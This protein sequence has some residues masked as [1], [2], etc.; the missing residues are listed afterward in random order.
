M[1]PFHAVQP[2]G[3][4]CLSECPPQGHKSCQ[5]TLWAPL[6]MGLQI[7]SGVCSSAGFPQGHS[8][9]QAVSPAFSPPW[10][11]NGS[12]LHYGPPWVA[13]GQPLSPWSSPWAA[14]ASLLLYWSNS[15]PSF[16]DLGADKVVSLIY[17]H[18]SLCCNCIVFSMPLNT[19]STNADGLLLAQWQVHL[20]A[21]SVG[22]LTEATSLVP[23]CLSHRKSIQ[24]YSITP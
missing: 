13:G 8:L 17:F 1:G 21:R 2:Y 4:E 24:P 23:F 15:S 16:T 20:R 3:T 12:L 11:G 14:G 19:L 22:N 9:H 7:L 10:A 5:I 18:S 6:S